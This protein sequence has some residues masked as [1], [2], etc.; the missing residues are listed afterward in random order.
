M[1]PPLRPA[2][3]N[4]VVMGI[5]NTSQDND[6]TEFVLMK[7]PTFAPTGRRYQIIPVRFNKLLQSET[8][9]SHLDMQMSRLTQ[10]QWQGAVI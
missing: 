9:I 4:P 6:S 3:S 10:A 7:W 2:A 5:G 8:L 1:V